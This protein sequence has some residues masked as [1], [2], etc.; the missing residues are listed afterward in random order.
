MDSFNWIL[1]FVQVADA[2]SFTAA[3]QQLGVSASAVGKTVARLEARYGVQLFRRSTRSLKLTPEG[4]QFLARCRSIISEA[5][6]AEEELRSN[7]GRPQGLLRVSLPMLGEAFVPAMASF[8]TAYP[9]VQLDVE[10]TDRKVDLVAENFDAV[11]RTGDVGDSRLT[12][13]R[14]GRFRMVLAAAPEYLAAQGLPATPKDLERHRCIVFRVPATGK[15]QPWMLK[16]GQE[17]V[18]FSP[19]PS[20]ICNSLRGRIEY[21]LAGTGIAY[22]PD[23]VVRD[24]VS[25]GMLALVLD[26]R[27][28]YSNCLHLIW[29]AGRYQTPKLRAFI[30]HIIKTVRLEH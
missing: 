6:A 29:R 19:K 24:A 22:L 28:A 15:L 12:A 30:D 27:A 2:G 7:Y 5:A 8:Q 1:V 10:F 4:Q 16:E 18:A 11:F 13:R 20:T 3:G 17:L 26:E 9:D 21:A 25:E 23:F 14:L